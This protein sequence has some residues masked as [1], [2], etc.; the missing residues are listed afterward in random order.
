MQF[1]ISVYTFPE[2]SQEVANSIVNEIPRENRTMERRDAFETPSICVFY[3]I[4]GAVF[5]GFPASVFVDIIRTGTHI[6][7]WLLVFLAPF[8]YVGVPVY[9]RSLL[10]FARFLDMDLFPNFGNIEQIPLLRGVGL[11]VM[12]AIFHLFGDFYK[13]I[14]DPIGTVYLA[15]FIGFRVALIALTVLHFAFAIVRWLAVYLRGWQI[16]RVPDNIE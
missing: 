16:A 4:L 9:T 14:P 8:V 15:P 2:R 11:L 3:M 10:S 13:F 6:Q 12:S 7:I 5:S 1:C